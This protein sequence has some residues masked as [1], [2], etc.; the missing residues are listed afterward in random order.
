MNTLAS[1]IDLPRRKLL[2]LIATL[3]A[4]VVT[5]PAIASSLPLAD[6]GA[7]NAQASPPHT[8]FVLS[9]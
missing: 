3:P 1:P 6:R 5:L 9:F 7:S 4:G 8:P 2:T